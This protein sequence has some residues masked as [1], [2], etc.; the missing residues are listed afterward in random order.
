MKYTTKPRRMLYDFFKSHSESCYTADELEEQMGETMGKATLYRTLSAFAD[1]GMIIK[2]YTGEGK[3]ASYRFKVSDSCDFHFHLR[4]LVC[5][6]LYHVD[7][8]VM[9]DMVDHIRRE[10]G[11]SVDIV[12]TTMYGVCRECEA[13]GQHE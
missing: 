7:C 3:P 12:H 13:G 5:G 4:C 8:E 2:Y 11:F 10:H 6:K 9:D 1:E